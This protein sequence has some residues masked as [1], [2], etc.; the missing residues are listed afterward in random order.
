M[1]KEE[2]DS[3]SRTSTCRGIGVYVRTM[4]MKKDNNWKEDKDGDSVYVL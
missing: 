1:K 4:R 2:R 3:S